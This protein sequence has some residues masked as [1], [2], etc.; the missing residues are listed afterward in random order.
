MLY[1]TTASIQRFSDA[2]REFVVSVSGSHARRVRTYE[3][4]SATSMHISYIFDGL[5]VA[6]VCVFVC[7]WYTLRTFRT[8]LEPLSTL[9]MYN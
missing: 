3:Q 5:M 8:G 4:L 6:H 1:V 2:M 9:H 7:E